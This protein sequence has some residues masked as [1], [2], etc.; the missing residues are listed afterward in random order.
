MGSVLKL[1]STDNQLQALA[2]IKYNRT[3]TQVQ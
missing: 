3:K 1:F 2:E